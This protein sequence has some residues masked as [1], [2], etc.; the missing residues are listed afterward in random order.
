MMIEAADPRTPDLICCDAERFIAETKL[1]GTWTAQ[2]LE[3][4]RLLRDSLARERSLL[5]DLEIARN[6]LAAL[7]TL[8][9]A[10]FV[11]AADAIRRRANRRTF[12]DTLKTY[13]ERREALRTE[14]GRISTPKADSGNTSQG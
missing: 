7:R 2:G 14:L 3:A 13:D 4:R 9:L 10:P 8:P 5:R 11:F 6:E 12:P 1:G